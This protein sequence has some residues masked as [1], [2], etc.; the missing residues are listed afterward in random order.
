[1]YGFLYP[2]RDGGGALQ[3]ILCTTAVAAFVFMLCLAVAAPKS[4][5]TSPGT[6]GSPHFRTE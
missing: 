5:Q 2:T 3:R 1:M 4:V 6:G